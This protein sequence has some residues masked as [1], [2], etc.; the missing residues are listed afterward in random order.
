VSGGVGRILLY[1]VVDSDKQPLKGDGP[2]SH[3]GWL[4]SAN[5]DITDPDTYADFKKMLDLTVVNLQDKA[6][7]AGIWIRPRSQ[8]PVGFG[9]ETLTRFSAEANKGQ[10]VT[11]AQLGAD[12]ALYA[13][14]GRRAGSLPQGPALPRRELGRLGAPPLQPRRRPG[15]VQDGRRRAA[16]APVQPPL[17]RELAAHGWTCTARRQNPREAAGQR[18]RDGAGRGRAARA[19]RRR[20][21]AR[22]APCQLL[23]LA[24][25]DTLLTRGEPKAAR[26]ALR[27]WLLAVE[28]AYP[29]PSPQQP[30][31]AGLDLEGWTFRGRD[32]GRPLPLG[33]A[34]STGPA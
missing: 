20:R 7:F 27:Y 1:E 25:L 29:E 23:A 34:N 30:Q 28:R 24:S 5:A 17:H 11:R 15:D 32:A 16:L 4:E 9:P 19:R 2:Y 12:Q 10:S 3:I 8:L 6:R 31:L 21:D 14:T 13:R 22:P 26:V 33:G 18:Q